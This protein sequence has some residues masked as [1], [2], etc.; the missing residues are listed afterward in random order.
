MRFAQK[1]RPNAVARL[2]HAPSRRSDDPKM[3]RKTHPTA[4]QHSGW[5]NV[6]A[7]WLEVQQPTLAHLS[8][9]PLRCILRESKTIPEGPAVRPKNSGT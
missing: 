8:G 6:A 2:P 7:R 1:H 3:R 5:S 9:H 4:K